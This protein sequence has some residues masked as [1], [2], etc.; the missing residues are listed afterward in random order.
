MDLEGHLVAL[1]L[2][3][4]ILWFFHHVANQT[5]FTRPIGLATIILL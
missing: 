4:K 1:V 5:S 3:Q 2:D